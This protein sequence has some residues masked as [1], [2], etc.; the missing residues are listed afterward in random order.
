MMKETG[1]LPR[2]IHMIIK[3]TIVPEKL[4]SMQR[5]SHQQSVYNIT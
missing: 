2:K 4:L 5:M 1:H 3:F